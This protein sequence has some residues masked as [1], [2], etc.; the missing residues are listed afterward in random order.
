VTIVQWIDGEGIKFLVMIAIG[1]GSIL[2]RQLLCRLD[3]ISGKVDEL[4]DDM[5]RVKQQLRIRP[6]DTD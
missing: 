4:H 1:M 3:R 5:I 6:H 2:A